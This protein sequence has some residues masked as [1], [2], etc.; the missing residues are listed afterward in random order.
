MRGF[1]LGAS[2]DDCD[3]CSNWVREVR[4]ISSNPDNNGPRSMIGFEVAIVDNGEIGPDEIGTK[5]FC[6]PRLR[7]DITAPRSMIGFGVV[8]KMFVFVRAIDVPKP[9]LVL[10]ATD[11]LHED[12]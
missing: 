5:E 7:S 11:G 10:V 2:G 4:S 6:P 3:G 9:G 8:V 1:I 12:P